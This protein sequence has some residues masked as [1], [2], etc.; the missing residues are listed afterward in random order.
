MRNW[1][2]KDFLENICSKNTQ[3]IQTYQGLGFFSFHI[4]MPLAKKVLEY[5][6]MLLQLRGQIG[7]GENTHFCFF[8]AH[9][10][11]RRCIKDN[12]SI[13]GQGTSSRIFFCLLL[14]FIKYYAQ[15][16]SLHSFPS[17][18]RAVKELTLVII[19]TSRLA[20]CHNVI[21]I[22]PWNKTEL[23]QQGNSCRLL[24]CR[25]SC[26]CGAWWAPAPSSFWSLRCNEQNNMGW[27]NGESKCEWV[28]TCRQL[29]QLPSYC[30]L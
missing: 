2:D 14:S 5:V 20:A 23:E 29:P 27:W 21:L 8:S 18:T 15:Q 3:T 19:F 6:I 25:C 13:K 12:I 1:K 22:L 17:R 24:H 9:T 28:S 10:F 16:Y 11:A 30:F 26:C 4:I 7:P